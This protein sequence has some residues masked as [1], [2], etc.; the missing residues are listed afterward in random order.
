MFVEKLTRQ[1]VEVFIKALGL[2][3]RYEITSIN[4]INVYSLNKWDI[5]LKSKS[6]GVR[7]G[8]AFD[9]F[10]VFGDT[11]YYTKNVFKAFMYAKFGEE[12]K[13]AFNERLKQKYESELI[14]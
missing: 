1:D 5:R 13:Q 3:E 10:V 14:K 2:E 7:A 8:I 6:T 4:H 12:Y 11:N 9:D